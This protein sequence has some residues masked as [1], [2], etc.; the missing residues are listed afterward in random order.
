MT[1]KSKAMPVLR[2]RQEVV[3]KSHSA[4]AVGLIVGHQVQIP[5]V[6]CSLQSLIPPR[7]PKVKRS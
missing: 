6:L 4:A 7:G 2:E 5:M 1:L 3:G